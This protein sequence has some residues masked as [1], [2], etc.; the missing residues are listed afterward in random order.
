[1]KIFDSDAF[2]VVLIVFTA[3]FLLVHL[4]LFHFG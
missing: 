4:A 3:L 2:V 1:M